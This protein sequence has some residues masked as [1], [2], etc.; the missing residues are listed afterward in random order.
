MILI[1][2]AVIM[3]MLNITKR[4]FVKL[5]TLMIRIVII[6]MDMIILRESVIMIIVGFRDLSQFSLRF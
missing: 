5:A 6:T 2:I 3:A 4:K 1:M